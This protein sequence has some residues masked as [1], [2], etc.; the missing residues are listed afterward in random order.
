M[1][2]SELWKVPSVEFTSINKACLPMCI[3]SIYEGITKMSRLTVKHP[4][5]MLKRC[6]KFCYRGIVAVSSKVHSCRNSGNTFTHLGLVTQAHVDLYFIS[7]AKVHVDSSKTRVKRNIRITACF[8]TD[9]EQHI[10]LMLQLLF[11]NFKA[12][13]TEVNWSNQNFREFC[14]CAKV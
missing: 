11:M 6:V 8:W 7:L 12:G 3:I 4:R 1:N 5:K 2:W 9:M 13:G 14:Q 10:A